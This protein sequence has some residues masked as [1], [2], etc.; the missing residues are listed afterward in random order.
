MAHAS[1]SEAYARATG[2]ATPQTSATQDKDRR[3]PSKDD[4]CPICYEGM[5]GLAAAKLTWCQ[6]CGN[7]L[8][9]ECFSQ[10][11]FKLV[12]GVL[13]TD[14]DYR[15]TLNATERPTYYLRVLQGCMDSSRR[16]KE[17]H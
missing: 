12:A 14:D 15:G 4:D 3:M 6:S 13:L 2:E 9:K 7:V 8:H 17:Y 5:H 16:C 10:C 11:T 1:I